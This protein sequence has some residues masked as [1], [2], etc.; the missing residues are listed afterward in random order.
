[1]QKLIIL[2]KH[3]KTSNTLDEEIINYEFLDKLNDFLINNKHEYET[4]Q[5]KVCLFVV[6]RIYRRVKLGYGKAFGGIKIDLDH[7][8]IIDGN[9]RYIAYKLAEYDFEIIKYCKNHCDSPPYRKINDF[10]VD[11]KTDWD[12]SHPNTKKYCTDD[13]LKDYCKE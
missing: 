5:V 2:N 8:L 12:K 4:V 6:E 7:N 11:L 9:H 13:F 3:E 10:E 1:M